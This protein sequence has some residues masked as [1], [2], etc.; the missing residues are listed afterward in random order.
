MRYDT[1]AK[2]NVLMANDI[3]KAKKFLREDK[4][5]EKRIELHMHTKM[6]TMDGVSNAKDLISTAIRWG[7]KAIAVTDHGNIQAFPEAM[8]TA[9]SFERDGTI[10]HKIKVI[11]GV[12]AYIVNDSVPIT[13]GETDMTYDGDFVVFDIET[14]G[15]RAASDGIT[16]IGAVKVSGG[17]VCEVFNTFVNPEKPIPE[18]IVHL[19]GIT[20][21]MVADA[22][23]ADKA[24]ADFWNFQRLRACCA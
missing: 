4:S 14:T 12:E 5:E 1:F 17:K 9:V 10:N 15:L 8:D 23:T 18:N 19:T 20:D 13:F 2:E 11:Y 24:V 21:A 7:H 16:E 22:P 3:E 6:S